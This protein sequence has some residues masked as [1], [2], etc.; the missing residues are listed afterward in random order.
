MRN[1]LGLYGPNPDT[2]CH[3]GWGGS[4]ALAD[5]ERR[6]SM[7]YVMNRQSNSLQGDPRARALIDSVYQCL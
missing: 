5:P 6:L 2:L 1:N 7:A 3:S 4:M